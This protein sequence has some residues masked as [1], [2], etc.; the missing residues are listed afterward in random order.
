MFVRGFTVSINPP[1][2]AERLRCRL[3]QSRTRQ[4]VITLVTIE[5]AT[6]TTG[7]PRP[8]GSQLGWYTDSST[9]VSL[10]FTRMHHCQK[11]L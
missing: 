11:H 7:L 8:L 9:V 6:E 5:V 3:Y 1:G 10:S 2:L 4:E